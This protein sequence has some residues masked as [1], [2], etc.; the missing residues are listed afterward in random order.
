MAVL[1]SYLGVAGAVVAV[2]VICNAVFAPRLGSGQ[3]AR[4]TAS[5]ITLLALL[6]T[7]A[8]A[9]T[10]AVTAAARTGT[11]PYGGPLYFYAGYAVGL[12]CFIVLN[13]RFRRLG[14]DT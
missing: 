3:S 13:R 2:A 8:V 6:V 4:G 12:V 1:V 7:P 5:V 11:F 9:A 10:I 14:D